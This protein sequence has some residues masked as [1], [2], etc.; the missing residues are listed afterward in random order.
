M[1]I[2]SQSVKETLD[3][4][5][6]IAGYLKPQ[7]IICLEGGLGTGKT[8]LTKGI[9][10]GLGIDKSE[11]TSSSFILIRQ[12]L[13]GRIPLYHFDLYRL[14]QASDIVTLGYEEY[15]YDEG[16]S[17]IEWAQNLTYLMPKE[18]LMVE[19]DYSQGNKRRLK[20]SASGTHYK[21]LL[22]R[23]NEDISHR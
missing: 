18:C 7:D 20:F 22:R 9:A 5:K 19:L 17:V 2:I 16:V 23:I 1:K 8:T 15:F 12:H 10:Q 14:K 3:L 21:E 4:G 13:G 11:V 6:V